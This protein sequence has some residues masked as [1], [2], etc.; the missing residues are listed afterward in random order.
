VR[1]FPASLL[2]SAAL[3]IPA[4]AAQAPPAPTRWVTDEAGFL[5]EGVR[6]TLNAQL[7]EYSRQS[8]HQ[9]VVWIG[10]TT[11]GEPIEDFAVRAFKAWQVGRKGLD[12]GVVLFLFSEDRTVHIEVGYGLEAQVPDAIASRIIRETIVPHL[13]S[14]D[15]DGAVVAGV[16]ALVAAI[17]GPS[18]P[19]LQAPRRVPGVVPHP[20]QGLTGLE[21]VLLGIAVIVFLILLVTH[22]ALAVYL[23]FDLL[24]EGGRGGSGGGG[25]GGFSGGG[26]R[27]GGG[28]ASGS[29]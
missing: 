8:G 25:G 28:G 24:S 11:G 27:S 29:W 23:L 18:S 13:Q 10:R 4:G 5:S 22:P 20:Q 15:R 14:G 19:P 6:T 2:L 16:Q 26:G 17:Q 12:D 9:L 7:E 3:A 1:R 21:M